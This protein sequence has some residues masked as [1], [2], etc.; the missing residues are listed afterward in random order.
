LAPHRPWLARG[1]TLATD[2]HFYE[3]FPSRYLAYI[4]RILTLAQ[5]PINRNSEHQE[6]TA[7]GRE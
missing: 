2:Y 4:R 3:R 6:N 5:S 7:S 1:F